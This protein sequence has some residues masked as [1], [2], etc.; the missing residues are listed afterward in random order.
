[1]IFAVDVLYLLGLLAVGA[2]YWLD[3]PDPPDAHLAYYLIA[4]LVGYRES[5][6]RELMKRLVDVILSPAVPA[7]PEVMSPAITDVQPSSIGTGAGDVTIL[8]SGLAAATAVVFGDEPA[9][10]LAGTDE[11][12]R[13]HAPPALRPDPSRWS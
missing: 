1:V 5:T 7:A 9:E 4:F 11:E 6:F 10:L 12:L 13:V 8:G 2:L 3:H